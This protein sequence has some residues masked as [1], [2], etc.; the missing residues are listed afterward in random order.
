MK[1]LFIT[2]VTII[3]VA[4]QTSI[5]QKQEKPWKEWSKADAEKMLNNSAWGQL[6]VDTDLSEMFFNPQ[7]IRAWVDELRMQTRDWSKA[8]LI[9]QRV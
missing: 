3:L 6:Q 7:A 8:L 9:R 1:K 4:S 5:G 2:F